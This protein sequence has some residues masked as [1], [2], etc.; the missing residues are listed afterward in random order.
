MADTGLTQRSALAR[1]LNGL[2]REQHDYR[3]SLEVF[4]ALNVGKLA[5]DMALAATGLE[6]ARE[7]PASDGAT[8]DDV[9]AGSSSASK[10][11]E[12]RP[13]ASRRAA[14]ARSD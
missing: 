1:L 10:R 7:E 14:P 9:E 5:G 11:E 8:F 3:P 13:R 2:K 4:P 12:C 6:L